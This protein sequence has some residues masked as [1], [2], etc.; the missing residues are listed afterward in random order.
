MLHCRWFTEVDNRYFVT[1]ANGDD[2]RRK[3]NVNL[4]YSTLIAN[5]VPQSETAQSENNQIQKGRAEVVA[6]MMQL[7]FQQSH[8]L[9]GPSTTALDT[10]TDE[11]DDGD[12]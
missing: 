5:E 8:K 7:D 11:S 2:D 3:T 12:S 9:P 1:D 10:T 6:F 4:C